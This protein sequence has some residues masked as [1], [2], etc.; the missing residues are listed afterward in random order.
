MLMLKAVDQ[1]PDEMDKFSSLLMATHS[2][3]LSLA[4]LV[5]KFLSV[6]PLRGDW[7]ASVP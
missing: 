5:D 6:D 3:Q 2:S 7:R 1:L 4:L